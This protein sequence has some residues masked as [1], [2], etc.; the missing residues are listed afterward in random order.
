MEDLNHVNKRPHKLMLTD[1]RTC[2]ISGVNDVLS[3]DVNEILLETEQGMLMIRG[4]QLHVS[5]LSLDKGEVDVDGRIDSFTY[6]ENA[7]YGAKGESFIARL[8]K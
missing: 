5:R 4:T 1:R 8:F 7:G 3:F 2:T 6:S